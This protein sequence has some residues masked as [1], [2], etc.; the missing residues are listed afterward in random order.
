MRLVIATPL[1]PP[2]PGGPAT[3]TRLLETELPKQGIEVEVLKFSEVRHLPK[4]IRHI[5][6]YFRVLKAARGA[7]AVLAL[8]PVSVGAPAMRAAKKANKPFYVKVVGDYA[9]EQGRQRFGVTASLDDFVRAPSSGFVSFLQNR[10][11]E[12][13]FAAKL[14]IVPSVYLKGIVESWGVPQEKITVIYNTA[15]VDAIGI[16]PDSVLRLKR[17]LIVTVGRLVPWKGI[18][19]LIDAVA[20]ARV[21]I[22]DLSLAVVGDGP[23][24]T[25][26]EA[27]ARDT[28]KEGYAFTGKISHEDTLAVMKAGDVFALNTAY[29]GFSHVLLEACMLKVPVLTTASGGNVELVEDEKTALLAPV[30]DVSGMAAQMVR[31]LTEVGLRDRLANAAHARTESTFGTEAL[32]SQ[33]KAALTTV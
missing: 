19:A 16:V 7:D 25:E 4:L 23:M 28:L 3:Y 33:L 6:Y 31:L 30:D 24:R 2:E 32:I 11:Q 13:A 15:S 12:V 8:D 29:E 27:R 10:Q 22:P 5:A 9:W 20:A 14:V 26:L 18:A 1:Y 17:P 21:T